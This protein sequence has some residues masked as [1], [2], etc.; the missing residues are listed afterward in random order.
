MHC[1]IKINYVSNIK[2][3][4]LELKKPL[5]KQQIL[6]NRRFMLFFFLYDLH[7]T[8][9]KIIFTVQYKPS[10]YKKFNILRAPYKNKIAQNSYAYYRYSYNVYLKTENKLLVSSHFFKICLHFFKNGFLSTNVNFIKCT[11]FSKFY[12]LKI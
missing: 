11:E 1:F 9:S 6:F 12:K 8:N 2:F 3:K 5:A 7:F 4:Q 10:R